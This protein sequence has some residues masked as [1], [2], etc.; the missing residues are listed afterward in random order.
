M[1]HSVQVQKFHTYTGHSDC[2]Y[3]LEKLDEKRF[4][5]SGADGMVVMWD[6]TDLEKGQVLAKLSNSC[7]ALRYVEKKGLLIVGQNFEGIHLIDVGR[8]QEVGSL[9]LNETEIFDIQ[10]DGDELF[11]ATGSGEI[12]QVMLSDL[13]VVKRI[14]GSD[15]R[16]RTIALTEEFLIVGFSDN[17]IRVY[18]RNKQLAL[19]TEFRAHDISVFSLQVDK[20]RGLLLSGSRDAHLKA[21]QLGTFELQQDVVAHMYAIN[22]ICYSDDNQHFV[23]CSMDKSI[24]IWDAETFQ[25]VKVIDKARHAGHATSVNKLLWMDHLGFLVSCSDDQSIA[26]WEIKMGDQ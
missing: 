25:L 14:E 15:K 26:V 8:R 11:V 16:A 18:N 19:V 24:K 3:T 17:Y 7:Y 23:T 21:W 4:V 5:S 2:L 20:E 22:H 13:K 1:R 10:L 6:L 12:F 9:K